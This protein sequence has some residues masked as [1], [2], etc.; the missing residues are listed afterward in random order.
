M[1]FSPEILARYR[2]LNN[3]DHIRRKRQS[4]SSRNVIIELAIFTDKYET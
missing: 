4:P 1:V 3:T 2:V